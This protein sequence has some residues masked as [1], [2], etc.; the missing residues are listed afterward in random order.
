MEFKKI[1]WNEYS[2]AVKTL[3]HEVF[4]VEQNVDPNEE[5]DGLDE[6]ES[7][8]HFAAFD[9]EL[10]LVAYARLL[11]KGKIGRMAVNEKYRNN[12][13]GSHLLTLCMQ[14]ALS[15]DILNDEGHLYLHAQTR[16]KNFYL[17]A[18]FE[19]FG[20][21]FEEAGIEHITMIFKPE[22]EAA[23]ETLFTDKVLRFNALSN[24]HFHLK[25][26]AGHCLRH[27]DILSDSLAAPIFTH[28]P[29]VEALSRAAR[30]SRNSRIRVLLR[31]SKKLHGQ[32]HPLVLLAQRLSTRMEIR[33]LIEEPS[34]PDIAYLISDS[35]KLV[36]FNNEEQQVGFANYRAGPEAQSLLD[37]FENLW[38]RHSRRDPNLQRLQI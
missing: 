6:L 3:R 22:N 9:H 7:T 31:D 18:G 1:Q 33:T 35:K 25:T 23:I 10:E 8:H 36:Y 12:K 19:P 5:F 28:E 24:I 38:N 20:E 32:S 15:R 11:D 27:I 17:R 14:Y 26:V 30:R 4:I 2:D 34:K 29:F 13:V 16:A 21:I 37:E